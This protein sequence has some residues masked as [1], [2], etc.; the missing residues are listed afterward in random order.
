MSSLKSKDKDLFFDPKY[1]RYVIRVLPGEYAVTAKKDHML[2]TTLGSCVAACIRDPLTGVGGMNHFLLPQSSEFTQAGDKGTRYGN[3]AMELLINDMLK[4]GCS[5]SRFEIKVF[6]G[7]HIGNTQISVGQ[8][9]VEFIL[10]YIKDEEMN[11]LSKDLGGT[12]ARKIH[13]FPETGRVSR[14]LMRDTRE[15][16]K[17]ETELVKKPVVADTS[18]DIELFD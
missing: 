15:I 9:N 1:E 13:Y 18:D 2:V 5:R 14:Q 4:M 10:K 17:Q 3:H 6:G 7:G 11:L 12:Q 16:S 8:E